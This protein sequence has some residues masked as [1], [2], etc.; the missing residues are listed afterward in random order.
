MST[1][2]VLSEYSLS[3]HGQLELVLE[4]G[5]VV[6]EVGALH[7][8]FAPTRDLRDDATRLRAKRTTHSQVGQPS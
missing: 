7:H 4:P 8:L 5:E 6:L 1:W 3:T 2:S